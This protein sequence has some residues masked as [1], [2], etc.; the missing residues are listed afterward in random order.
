MKREKAQIVEGFV[1]I[2]GNAILFGAKFWVGVTTGSI[3]LV[4]DA[5]HTLSDSL[6]SIFVVVAAK[7]ASKKPDKEHPF[8]HGRWELIAAIMIAFLLIFIG[9]EFLTSSIER[10]QNQDGVVYGTLALV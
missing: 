7:L 1:S 5:W 6:T 4:A 9:Y 2:V 8:G 10:F 3:A